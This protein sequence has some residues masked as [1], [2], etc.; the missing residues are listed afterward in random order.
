MLYQY[1]NSIMTVNS[2]YLINP[3]GRVAIIY[4]LHYFFIILYYGMLFLLQKM[5]LI[6]ASEF[7]YPMLRGAR[8]IGCRT[9]WSADNPVEVLN[10][11]LSSWLDVI[12][13]SSYLCAQ[14]G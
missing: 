6:P 14:Q 12:Y 4:S 13:Q 11:H 7:D 2:S 5:Y 3:D 1:Y 8:L 10:K 9:I